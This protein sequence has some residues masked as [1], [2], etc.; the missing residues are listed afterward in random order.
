M[1]QLLLQKRRSA[2]FRRSN[3]SLS[4]SSHGEIP[5]SLL[6]NK[7]LNSEGSAEEHVDDKKSISSISKDDASHD[8][9]EANTTRPIHSPGTPVVT[10]QQTVQA[11]LA[12]PI[13]PIQ[14]PLSTPTT[15]QP[16]ATILS[17]Y[18][19]GDGQ[20]C[21]EWFIA[22]G[23]AVR[24][25]IDKETIQARSTVFDADEP[26]IPYFDWMDDNYRDGLGSFPDLTASWNLRTMPSDVKLTLE[27]HS[28][29]AEITRQNLPTISKIAF[30]LLKDK[31]LKYGWSLTPDRVLDIASSMEQGIWE[32]IEVCQRARAF[33]PLSL[34]RPGSSPLTFTVEFRENFWTKPPGTTNATTT[35][36]TP[37]GNP[38]AAPPAT[39][40]H[41]YLVAAPIV[42]L[43][44]RSDI[45]A[46]CDQMAT[47]RLSRPDLKWSAT[48]TTEQN[49]WVQLQLRIVADSYERKRVTL[50][51]HFRLIAQSTD[52]NNRCW[53]AWS[54]PTF[55]QEMLNA[56]KKVV[57]GLSSS[58]SLQWQVSEMAKSL[59]WENPL[60]AVSVEKWVETAQNTFRSVNGYTEDEK[61]RALLKTFKDWCRQSVTN[62]A[63]TAELKSCFG[64]TLELVNNGLEDNIRM[65]H[66][67]DLLTQLAIEVTTLVEVS[68]TA[69]RMGALWDIKIS[70]KLTINKSYGGGS[71]SGHE[72]M[73]AEDDSEPQSSD[74]V[75]KKARTT[76]KEASKDVPQCRTCGRRHNFSLGGSCMWATH[77]DAFDTNQSGVTKDQS[78][79]KSK[80]GQAYQ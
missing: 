3:P 18:D 55:R 70:K 2:K 12:P 5:R 7:E 32:D 54:V 58:H 10:P 21:L 13:P 28:T 33:N 6:P 37:I 23:H 76:L 78:W 65:M 24:D 26:Y 41:G 4:P 67:D 50:P 17:R 69:S 22:R 72:T 35:T 14:P 57:G 11:P 48:L 47:A 8:E 53:D 25:A 63:P 71:T 31:Y 36:P 73:K 51:T 46:Y 44:G 60:N 38:I 40:S 79:A 29:C 43:K 59:S 74:P 39:L 80:I 15:Q 52:F 49:Q 75:Q 9:E 30:A 62:T 20:D 34:R 19:A 16:S 1:S 56:R 77:P 42:Q 27:L 64:R 66:T 61:L 45:T 68:L